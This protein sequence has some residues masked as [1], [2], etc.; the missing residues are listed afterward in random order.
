MNNRVRS[1]MILILLGLLSGSANAQWDRDFILHIE[2]SPDGRYVAGVGT[3]VVIWDA[4]SGV[5]LA[6]FDLDANSPSV[7]ALD[8]TWSP[9]STRLATLTDDRIVTVRDLSTNASSLGAKVTEFELVEVDLARNIDWSPDGNLIAI[10]GGGSGRIELWDGTTFQFT[11]TRLGGSYRMA[12]NPDPQRELIAVTNAESNGAYLIQTGI[13]ASNA[14]L[15]V[16]EICAPEAFAVPLAWNSDG[17]QIAIG[18]SDGSIYVVDVDINSTLVQMQAIDGL[19][20]LVWSYDDQYLASAVGQVQIWDASTG[21]LLADGG[22]ASSIDFHPLKNELFVY[23]AR[24]ESTHIVDVALHA[25]G[26]SV[27]ED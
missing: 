6:Q 27:L 21:A 13:N 2:Y 14:V 26:V 11:R 12:W 15:Q 10:S 4:T 7:L 8:V 23:D 16:C 22:I 20:Y 25:T 5:A 17:S 18:H 3:Y 1:L 19:G 9:D 24:D